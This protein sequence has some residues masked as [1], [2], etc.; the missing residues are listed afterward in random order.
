MV[1]VT[2]AELTDWPAI[3][4]IF[5]AVVAEGNTYAF[6]PDI[7]EADAL[8]IWMTPP[9]RCYIARV[10][11]QIVGTCI[12][13]P[14][15]PGLGDHV[16]NAAFMVVQDQSGQGIGR[17]LGHFALDESRRLGF[18][19]I[20][21]HYVVS[22]NHRAIKLWQSLGFAIVGQVP[23]AFRHQQHGLVDV[24]VMHRFL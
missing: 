16:A 7:A 23:Q 15:Q 3:W 17:A 8:L 14:N 12:I 9:A 13:K 22:T 4:P 2:L 11:E 20:K 10:E 1:Q 18:V 6:A 21:V 5:H 19:A 24:Y